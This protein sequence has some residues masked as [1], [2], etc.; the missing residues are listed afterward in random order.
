MLLAITRS[1]VALLNELQNERTACHDTAAA[2]KK[3]AADNI[4]QHGTFAA[5]LS[6]Y[7]CN[8]GKIDFVTS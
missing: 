6:A 8:L 2:G 3:V 1:K 7:D 4:L 5:R